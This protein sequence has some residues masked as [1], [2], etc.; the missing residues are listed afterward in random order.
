MANTDFSRR[1]GG[2]FAPIAE[3]AVAV[4]Y[5][6]AEFSFAGLVEP[7]KNSVR[8][9][10]AAMI[11]EEIIRVVSLGAGFM[12][13]ARGCCDTVPAPHGIGELIWFYQ[14]SIG[15]DGTEYSGGEEI[16]VKV[17]PW[18]IGGGVYPVEKA[19]PNDLKMNWRFYRPYAPG[20]MLSNG[21]PW[22]NTNLITAD[23]GGLTLTWAH[24]DRVLQADQII[25][26]E[27][28]DIGPEPGS[29]YV[30]RVYDKF[31]ALRRTEVGLV[32]KAWVYA[33]SQ[34][35]ADMQLSPA[36]DGGSV[37]QGVLYFGTMRDNFHSWQGYM[38]PFTVDNKA[39][40]VYVSQLATMTAQP[41]VEESTGE[42]ALPLTGMFVAQFATMTAQPPVEDA[43]DPTATPLW[44]MFVSQLVEPTGQL[45]AL[46]GGIN[47]NLFEAPYVF[48][49]RRGMSP[50]T[51]RLMTVV[52]RPSDRLTDAHTLRTRGNQAL[53]FTLKDTP[54]FTPWV[55]LRVRLVQLEK[56]AQVFTSSFYDG[57]SLETVQPGQLALIDA[58]VVRVV[59]V[60]ENEIEL[61]RGCA[62]TIPAIHSASARMWFFDA[63]HG[64]D[65][66]DW[67]NPARDK[68]PEWPV[69]EAKVVPD[70]YGT[71]LELSQVPT[72][73]LKM[74][75]RT[76][77]PYPPGRVMANGR[78]WFEGGT[79]TTASPL[80]ISWV[81]RNRLTQD[82][83]V[84]DHGLPGIPA[85]P[86]TTYHIYM[87][88]EKSLLKANGTTQLVKLV[89]RDE[90]VTGLSYTY[91]AEMAAADGS[92]AGQLLGVCGSV[93][94]GIILTAVRDDLVSWQSYL[95]PVTCPSYACPP[96]K[97]SGGGWLPGYPSV[98]EN[99]NLG[100]DLD[101]HGVPDPFDNGAADNG[102]GVPDPVEPP[103][104]WDVGGGGSTPPNLENPDLAGH[105]DT[106]WDRHWD[107][108]K[109]GGPGDGQG[110]V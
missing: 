52:A 45:T 15:T 16:T 28:G 82:T 85:E 12:S 4:D 79:P 84:V 97:A 11:G 70:T 17:L 32:G 76:L 50:A 109:N 99:G 102:S 7:T 30:A 26:H 100:D 35:L 63:A 62:D 24:R 20:Q 31:G 73:T 13:V 27:V 93:G 107:A 9:G 54:R 49:A 65:I 37:E 42:P 58:E 86:G 108:Y 74:K 92:R 60:T 19:P 101:N 18:T 14:S 5:L 22:Y 44:G 105:W 33:W 56:L 46:Y 10:M 41:F 67:P 98:G 61:A 110:G 88:V 68:T 95:I 48:L 78:P 53:P 87:S 55:S 71:T 34:A 36:P 77:R 29:T 3:L 47:R 57:V 104:G 21:I 8:P 69:V 91:T 39:P 94:M 72:D 66:T 75:V 51:S 96:G 59:R 40:F 106:N 89:L 103:A 81:P 38:I 25:G 64:L 23:N 6:T 83:T 80:V 1:G 43:A 90:Y 2:S